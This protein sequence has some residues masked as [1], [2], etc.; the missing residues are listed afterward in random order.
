MHMLAAL[1]LTTGKLFYRIR[2]R[3]RAAEFLDLLRMLRARWPGEKLYIVCD[4]FS[5]HHHSQVKAW[6]QDNAVEL[7]I[8]A[9]LRILAELDRGRVRGVALLRAQWHRPPLPRRA[10]RRHRRLRPLDNARAQPKVHFAVGSP[11]RTWTD[12]PVRAA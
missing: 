3:K 2:P 11:I 5:P 6:C 12:Y 10:E 1:D 7:V 4:N 8:P 9:D